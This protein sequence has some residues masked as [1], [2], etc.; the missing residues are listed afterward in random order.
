VFSSF[1]ERRHQ[2]TITISLQAYFFQA[3]RFNGLKR[4]QTRLDHPVDIEKIHERFMPVINDFIESMN[5]DELLRLIESKVDELPERTRTIFR[6]SR[7]EQL[8]IPE[9]SKALGLSEQTIKN[10]LSIALK[11]LRDGIALAIVIST[12]K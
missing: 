4:L 7:F 2:I 8:S 11:N 10:Q 1:W 9:I 5:H 12:F 6:M 3:V